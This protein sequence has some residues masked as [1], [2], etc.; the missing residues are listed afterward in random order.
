MKF[1][2]VMPTFNRRD[3]LIN[4]LK[5]LEKQTFPIK[6]FE[7]VIVDDG[8]SDNTSSAIKKFKKTSKLKINYTFVNHVGPTVARNIGLRKAKGEYIAL[9]N[10]DMLPDKHWLAEHIKIHEKEK[11]VAVLGFIDWDPNI[12]I[13]YFM[14]F[15]APYGPQ[16]DFRIKDW[17]NCGYKNFLTSNLTMDRK[18]LEM[19]NFN[20]DI[21][22]ASC[23][24]I[25]LGI[26]LEKRGIRVVY[27][28][29]AIVYHSHIQQ[30]KTFM[31]KML[32]VG[33][34]LNLMNRKFPEAF[35]PTEIDLL[36]LVAS[37]FY[38]LA[39]F[40]KNLYWRLKC[41]FF[42]YLGFFSDWHNKNMLSKAI[43]ITMR[44]TYELQEKLQMVL[45]LDNLN[46]TPVIQGFK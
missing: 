35:K 1:S 40:N 41:G 13:N 38:F 4:C 29:K 36:K 43:Y 14:R 27:N 28:P 9:V 16:F 26:R 39:F 15:I 33:R 21:N 45:G 22:F 10:D 20:E 31:R 32:I 17:N 5:H 8:S 11:G 37:R 24:D 7:V 18:W 42:Y 30:E 2:I 12:E 46:L 6:E 25:D 19:E 23:E 3:I 34:D 44:A